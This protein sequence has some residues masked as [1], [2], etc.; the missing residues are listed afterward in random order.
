MLS[1]DLPFPPTINSYYGRTRTG[2]VFI[3][4]AGKSFRADVITFCMRKRIKL[5]TGRLAMF[6]R[7]YPPDK[8]VRDL[9]NIVKATQD[10]LQKAGAYEN[11]SQID[12]L[13]VQ[14]CEQRRGGGVNVV[15][16]QHRTA[17]QL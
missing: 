8:R 2:Q 14:R 17:S 11:D 16:C 15:I 12:A 9:D 3:K 10:A 7:V 4:A 6:I 5:Q 1:I 13:N